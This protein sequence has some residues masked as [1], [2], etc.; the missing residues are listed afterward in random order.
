MI[1]NLAEQTRSTIINAGL[2]SKDVRY[3]VYYNSDDEEYQRCTFEEFML[4]AEDIN[5]D[6][7]DTTM[8]SRK[9]IYNTLQIVADTWWL[10]RPDAEEDDECWIYAPLPVS[11][12]DAIET[13]GYL[14][15]DYILNE[16]DLA[17]DDYVELV[18]RPDDRHEEFLKF[19]D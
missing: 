3:V 19:L 11:E 12:E 14:T 7:H 5:Y 1:V 9:I 2:S 10:R 6:E 13:S 16:V 18:K 17:P 8:Q 15:N 4:L